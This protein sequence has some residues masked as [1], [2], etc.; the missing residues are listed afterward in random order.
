MIIE[1]TE[2]TSEKTE[3]L[4]HIDYVKIINLIKL[5]F[6]CLFPHDCCKYLNGMSSGLKLQ[7]ISA[8]ESEFI[9]EET[10][11]TITSGVEHPVFHFISGQFGPLHPGLPCEVP[12]WFA[13][14][15]RKKGHCTIQPPDWMSVEN[16]EKVLVDERVMQEY[17]EIQFHFIE[18]AHLLL[19]HARDD[20]PLADQV[21]VLL[22]DIE[23]IRLNRAKLGILQAVKHV[24]GEDEIHV[25][26]M[27][28]FSS[29]EILGMKQFFSESLGVLSKLSGPGE[30]PDR[31]LERAA[32]AR[33][34]APPPP[35]LA[36]PSTDSGPAVLTAPARNLR[37]FREAT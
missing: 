37:K 15:L 18:I 10:L 8:S 4:I 29:L 25:I 19:H 9:G 33:R 2:Q 30:D 27:N 28:H 11:I 12:L 6:H 5:E 34:A 16:L 23:S 14:T 17:S 24:N 1:P 32:A 20:I 7:S 35:P 13:I 26:S 31:A 21:A 3:L 22:Q 36:R